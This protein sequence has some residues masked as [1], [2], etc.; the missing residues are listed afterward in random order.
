MDPALLVEWLVKSGVIIFLILTGF[1]Y[2]TL[3]ERRVLAR[4]QVRIGPNRA[5]PLGLLQPLA[6]GIKLL[7]KEEVI[8]DKADKVIFILAPVLTVIPAFV[9]LAVIPLG[10]EISILGRSYSLSLAGDVNVGVLYLLAVASISVY[11]IVLAGWSSNNKY[12]L[13]GGLRSAAQMISYELV[14]G[15]AFIGPILLANSMSLKDIIQA[16]SRVWFIVLQPIGFLLFLVASIA[17]V[18][19][20]PFDMPE[21]EQELTAGYHVEYSGM[22]F[23]LFFMAE[24]G[25]MIVVSF[26]TASLFLGGYL[27]PFV[28]KLPLLGPIYLLVKVTL[29]LFFM[30]WVRATW[31][32]IRYDR[33]MALGWKVLLPIG[34][35]NIIITAILV[36]LVGGY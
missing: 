1:A 5:G 30:I 14:L 25:K 11:G 34:L 36:I 15:L 17:E 8:P 27:G 26:I 22:K 13:L 12:A 24:Y 31:P 3:F 29:I 32:R 20:A 6:D 21:A 10:P 18:N 2:L 33:L 9:L 7:F 23:A 35:L 28:D 16:Q 4:I 19:R